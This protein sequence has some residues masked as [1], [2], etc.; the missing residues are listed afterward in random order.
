[1]PRENRLV[2]LIYLVYLDEPDEPTSN[3]QRRRPV[4]EERN[5]FIRVP[6][7]ITVISAPLLPISQKILPHL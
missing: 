2:A 6:Q 3:V 4:G 7:L 5:G 1:M